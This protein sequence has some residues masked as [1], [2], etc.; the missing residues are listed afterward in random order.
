M[1]TENTKAWLNGKDVEPD[2]TN[3]QKSPNTFLQNSRCGCGA[4]FIT[5]EMLR[6]HALRGNCGHYV[7]HYQQNDG[8][9]T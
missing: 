8:S 3:V 1:I 2:P 5:D 9:W 6:I 4:R 7:V